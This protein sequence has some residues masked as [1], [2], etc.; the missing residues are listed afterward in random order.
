MN[1]MDALGEAV[2]R[3]SGLLVSREVKGECLA[4]RSCDGRPRRSSARGD[5]SWL[6]A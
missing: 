4:S 6:G 1:D 3:Y 5:D 2:D